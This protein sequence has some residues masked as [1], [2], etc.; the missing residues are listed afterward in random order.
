M[1]ADGT[2]D[3]YLWPD[4][5]SAGGHLYYFLECISTYN[6]SLL[7]LCYASEESSTFF[8]HSGCLRRRALHI[9]SMCQYTCL[10]QSTSRRL[11]K[12]RPRRF[13]LRLALLALSFPQYWTNPASN[14]SADPQTG[15]FGLW[16]EGEQRFGDCCSWCAFLGDVMPAAL[17]FPADK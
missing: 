3:I 17:F 6:R 1:P 10:Y 4:K 16:R 7:S 8:A 13:P 5:N 15:V 2:L 12:N 14:P 9:R 11:K